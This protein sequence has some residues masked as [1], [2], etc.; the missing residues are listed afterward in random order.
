MRAFGHAKINEFRSGYEVW[1]YRYTEITPKAG[2]FVPIVGE[3]V[4]GS[5]THVREL[6]ILFNPAGVVTKFRVHEWVNEE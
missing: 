3:L 2:S 5:N 1:T 6:V 4:K